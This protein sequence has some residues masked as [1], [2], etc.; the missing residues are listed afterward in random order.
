MLAWGIVVVLACVLLALVFGVFHFEG[1]SGGSVLPFPLRPVLGPSPD[2]ELAA[3]R[4][5]AEYHP[6]GAPVRAAGPLVL[7]G[8]PTAT[9]NLG[10]LS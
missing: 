2:A 7:R 4:Y 9:L 6:G 1:P 3:C 8:S 10:V 5:L